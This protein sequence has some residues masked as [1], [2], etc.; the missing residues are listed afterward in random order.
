MHLISG[1]WF[2]FPQASL[3]F[4]PSELGKSGPNLSGSDETLTNLLRFAECSILRKEEP[5]C[6]NWPRYIDRNYRFLPTINGQKRESQEYVRVHFVFTRS[7]IMTGAFSMASIFAWTCLE[8]NEFVLLHVV[9]NQDVLQGLGSDLSQ[10]SI[11]MSS[12]R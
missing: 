9:L 8:M 12:G 5:R 4:H 6:I 1:Y 7:S 3:A 10:Q 2:E 11:C